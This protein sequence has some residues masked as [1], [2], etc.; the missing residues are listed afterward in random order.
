MTSMRRSSQ[1]MRNTKNILFDH[2]ITKQTWQ[3]SIS[4]WS[5]VDRQLSIRMAGYGRYIREE[6]MD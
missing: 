6:C 2:V 3:L 1:T 4:R 5:A